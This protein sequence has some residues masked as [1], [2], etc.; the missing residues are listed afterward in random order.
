MPSK[1]I[2]SQIVVLPHGPLHRERVVLHV[3]IQVGVVRLQMVRGAVPLVPT[4][5]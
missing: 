1:F 5:M 3:D 2:T 4:P